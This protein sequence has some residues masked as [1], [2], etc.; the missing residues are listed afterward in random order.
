MRYDYTDWYEVTPDDPP[1]NQFVLVGTSSS[2]PMVGRRCYCIKD[3]RMQPSC[4]FYI[5][6]SGDRIRHLK[7]RPIYWLPIKGGIK[8]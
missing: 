8:R 4:V 3:G 2:F 7:S 1:P 5:P 6:A